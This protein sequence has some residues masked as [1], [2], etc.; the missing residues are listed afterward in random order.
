M[1]KTIYSILAVAAGV[2]LASG[3][4]KGNLPDEN[5]VTGD[6]IL[7]AVLSDDLTK[8]AVDGTDKTKVNWSTGDALSVWGGENN[9]FTLSG[10]VGT[11]KGDFSGTVATGTAQYALYPYSSSATLYGGVIT[12]NVPNIQTVPVSSFDPAAAILVGTISGATITFHHAVAY[13]KITAP[14]DV[15]NLAEIT[16]ESNGGIQLTGDAKFT[17]ADGAFTATGT[18]SKSVTVKPAGGTF[19]AGGIYYAAVIPGTYTGGLT[20]R[21]LY[22]DNSAHTLTEKIKSNTTALTLQSGKA[23]LL[24]A[25]TTFDHTHEAVQLWPGSPY[26]ATTNIGAAT[27][28]DYGQYFAWGYSTGYY[29]DGGAWNPSITF[30]KTGFPDY[31]THTYSDMAAANWGI[32]WSVPTDA[33]FSTLINSTYTDIVYLTTP[34]KGIRVTGKGGWSNSIFLPAAGYGDG[35]TRFDSTSYGYYWSNKQYDSSDAWYL[36]FVLNTTSSVTNIQ[37]KFLGY[38]VRPVRSSY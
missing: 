32:G 21:Y 27:E 14:S 7:S 25:A 38:S 34:D 8:T 19:T 37:A 30:S 12:T 24:G 23:K 15:T 1:K 13:L 22:K 26:W 16:I 4:S 31:A 3:C 20:V 36:S 28:T 10:G 11:T 6:T 18:A 9:Q 2:I 35:S 17:G 5:N 33:D 29:R